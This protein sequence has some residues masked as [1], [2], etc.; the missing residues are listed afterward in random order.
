MIADH[1]VRLI[2]AI[3]VVIAKL[4]GV[5]ASARQ[6]LKLLKDRREHIRVVVRV[7][8][9]QHRHHALKP[10]P[11]IDMLGGQ[12]AQLAAFKSIVLDK[13]QVPQLNHLRVVGVD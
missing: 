3:G 5:G 2:D 10:H 7:L 1:A 11:R 9:L 6:R 13:H 4:A 8:A 12:L